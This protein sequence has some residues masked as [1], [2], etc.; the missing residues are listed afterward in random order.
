MLEGTDGCGKTVTMRRLAEVFPGSVMTGRFPGEDVPEELDS[1]W[2]RMLSCGDAQ[3][4]PYLWQGYSFCNNMESQERVQ[5]AALWQNRIVLADRGW[6]SSIC[7]GAAVGCS[8]EWLRG[9]VQPLFYPDL[10]FVFL[11]RHM[12]GP[13]AVER[14]DE[15]QDQVLRNYRELIEREQWWEVPLLP[16]EETVEWIEARIQA[17]RLP[18]VGGWPV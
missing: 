1:I 10:T 3:A 8:L 4:L 15:L 17:A 16:F 14:D 13:D 9:V 12:Q 6:P 11:H 5:R 7:Y 18:K 2:Q